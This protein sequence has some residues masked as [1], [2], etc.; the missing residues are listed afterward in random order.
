[1]GIA[2]TLATFISNL[3]STDV[4]TFGFLPHNIRETI[5]S[6]AEFS[7]SPLARYRVPQDRCPTLTDLMPMVSTSSSCGSCATSFCNN[8]DR[9]SVVLARSVLGS[10]PKAYAK[11]GMKLPSLR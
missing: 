8:Y 10:W 3:L 11:L 2:L 1:M 5:W 4:E 6:A 7:G 9:S